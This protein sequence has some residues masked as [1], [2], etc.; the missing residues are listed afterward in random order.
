MSVI[1]H[2]VVV[3]VLEKDAN[4][5]VVAG[6]VDQDVVVWAMEEDTRFR[7]SGADVVGH[8]V[9]MWVFEEN[10][11]IGDDVTIGH[12]VVVHG[13]KIESSALIGI[14]AILL[15]HAVVKSNTIV[16]AG[17]VVLEKTILEPNSL[18]AGVPVKRIKTINPARLETM[19]KGIA[20]NY[21]EYADWYKWVHSLKQKPKAKSLIQSRKTGRSLEVRS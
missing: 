2:S 18:Y 19:I 11:I 21:L 15:D 13:A 5:V 7:I 14:G 9:G 8:V 6:I 20:A 1:D 3:W 4:P 12:N 17:S 16:A 10:A